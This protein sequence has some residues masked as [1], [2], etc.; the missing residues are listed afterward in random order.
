MK[1]LT[2]LTTNHGFD[3]MFMLKLIVFVG[4]ILSAMAAFMLIRMFLNWAFNTPDKKPTPY[5]YSP[6]ELVETPS[7]WKSFK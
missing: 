6:S 5:N 7:H 4:L 2:W 1:L 3:G